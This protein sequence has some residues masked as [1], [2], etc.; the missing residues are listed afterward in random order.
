MFKK[1]PPEKLKNYL[2]ACLLLFLLFVGVGLVAIR[3]PTFP[4]K[5]M[6]GYAAARPENPTAVDKLTAAI[7]GAEG[8]VDSAVNRYTGLITVYGGLQ[9]LIGNDIVR[10]GAGDYTVARM[11]NG[12]IT[13][14]DGP[15]DPS[16]NAD[17]LNGFAA[18]N[19]DLGIPTLYMVL[20]VKVNKYED[21]MPTGSV[22]YGNGNSDNF[23]TMLDSRVDVLDLREDFN[24]AEQPYDYYFFNTDHH[25]TPEGAFLGFQS[26]AERLREDYGFQIDP[27][28]TDPANYKKVV[29]E[30]YFLGS[31][32]KRVGPLYAGVDDLTL[33]L[34][35]EETAGF[36]HS[37][38]HKEE[39]RTGSFED[40]FIYQE[41]V[42]EKNY[43]NL[44]PYVVYSGGDYPLSYAYNENDPS[45]KKILIIRQSYGCAFTPFL[46]RACS[47]LDILDPRYFSGSIRDYIK[48]SR[49]D[50][51]V[52]AYAAN[53]CVNSAI[54]NPLMG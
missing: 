23:L 40:A 41:M 34:P 28:V 54:F 18:Y 38:P 46:S 32:G 11:K 15:G 33:L 2:T 26:L 8:A 16:G 24:R 35:A 17:I 12:K 39:V 43:Y 5:F 49:P 25:W 1:Y 42:A 14:L 19:D 13:F 22:C 7:S 45:G 20:P 27:A 52:V 37:V 50:V 36:T 6:E 44:N 31:Q 9:R 21:T 4:D 3:I 30:D 53:D 10:D 29:Y 47:Q 48:E 51:V